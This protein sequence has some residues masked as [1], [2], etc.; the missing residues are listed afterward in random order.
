[1][2]KNVNTADV[3]KRIKK[4]RVS[5]KI[6]QEKMAELLG[7]T[8]SNYTKMEN[9]YQNITVKHLKNISKILEISADTLLFG[10]VKKYDALDFDDYIAFAKVFNKDELENTINNLQQILKLQDEPKPT[11]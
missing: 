9:A 6:S 7:V 11:S 1:M 5:K 8:F 4:V 3:A 2:P 10:R